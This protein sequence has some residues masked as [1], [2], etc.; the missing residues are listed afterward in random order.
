[1][2]KKKP[3]MDE[4]APTFEAATE[5]LTEIA[6]VLEDG[7]VPLDES[8]ARYEEG[9]ALIARCQKILREAEARIELLAKRADGTLEGEPF[10]RAEA[11]EVPDA[12]PAARGKPAEADE[13]DAEGL[14]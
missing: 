14:F 9:M 13:D 7:Q 6:S 4:Q 12:P 5:R 11:T 1:M 10:D 8:I 2:G 3:E